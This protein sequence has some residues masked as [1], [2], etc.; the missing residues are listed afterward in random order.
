[1][2]A[3]RIPL[4]AGDPKKLVRFTL[5]LVKACRETIR[6]S[7]ASRRS[8]RFMYYGRLE[9]G[10]KQLGITLGSGLNETADG[11]P[12][13]INAISGSAVPTA[14]GSIIKPIFSPQLCNPKLRNLLLHQFHS[15]LAPGSGS[16]FGIAFKTAK[17]V[18]LHQAGSYWPRELRRILNRRKAAALFALT[19]AGR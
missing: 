6:E 10:V 15:M 16:R 12:P 3:A 7:L 17:V 4:R 18:P 1:V 2:V 13:V 14:P 9:E 11:P 5:G 8:W 19:R